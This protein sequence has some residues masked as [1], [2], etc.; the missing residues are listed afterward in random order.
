MNIRAALCALGAGSFI[1]SMPAHA[2]EWY[3]S[4]SVGYL[5]QNDSSNTG[6]T[7]AFT[8]GNGAPALPFGT[9]VATGTPYG[10]ETEFDTGYSVAGEFGTAYGNGFRSGIEL[11]FSKADVDTHRRVNVAG[12]VIDGVDAAVLT[13]SD[14]QLGVTVGDVVAAPDGDKIEVTSLFANLYYDFNRDGMISPYVGAGIG[15][16]DVQVTY[17][18]SGVSI[19]DDSE[20]KLAYQL[21]A[22]ATWAISERIDLFGEAAYRTTD[23]ISVR[24]QL[25][26]GSLEIENTQTVL[27]LGAR[28]RFGG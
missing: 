22:G 10:W 17:R 13:G 8:T 9:P 7:G 5:M 12:T 25:F 19:I 15:Y 11:V 14:T 20:G 24:N 21:K 6:A 18:P 4:G 26:P 27:S 16:S 1:V 23:D 28:Y 2:Q 3:V